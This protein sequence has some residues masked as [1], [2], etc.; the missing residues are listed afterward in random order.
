[1]ADQYDPGVL[2][3]RYSLR[4][5]LVAV[6]LS[7]LIALWVRSYFIADWIGQ[8]WFDPA[9]TSENHHIWFVSNHGVLAVTVG[10]D[11]ASNFPQRK[12]AYLSTTSYPFRNKTDEPRLVSMLGVHWTKTH[13]YTTGEYATDFSIRMLTLAIVGGALMIYFVIRFRQARVVLPG[14]CQSCGYDLRASPS[15]CPEC[16]TPV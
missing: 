13:R 16:G 3:R 14:L 1:M 10:G 7:A 9:V 4:V 2:R 5:L 6:A 8:V 11:P 12:W 15:R